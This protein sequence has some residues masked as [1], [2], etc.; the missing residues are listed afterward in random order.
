[1]LENDNKGLS[2][3]IIETI[4]DYELYNDSIFEYF[5]EIYKN[6]TFLYND[7]LRPILASDIQI[8]N[9][10]DIQ[11]KYPYLKGLSVEFYNGFENIG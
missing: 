11:P 7:E 10:K 5:Y 2:N 9:K 6:S 4:I 3:K 8:M 1:M